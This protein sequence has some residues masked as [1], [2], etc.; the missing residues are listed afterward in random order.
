MMKKTLA[1]ATLL[2][3]LTACASTPAPAP[4]PEPVQVD[5]KPATPVDNTYKP[6]EPAKLDP[7]KDPS[8][9]LS[10]R[11]VYFDYD[12]YDVRADQAALVEAHGRY[13]ASN[14]GRSMRIEGN[15]DERGSREY[16]LALGQKR[17]E[18]VRRALST[19][20]AQDKQVEAISNGEEKPR[21]TGHDEGSYAENRRADMV[22]DGE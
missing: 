4:T 5:T 6:V 20:G 13:L 2:A 8:N 16:N 15:A 12:K 17:A 19:V 18:A 21:A 22:Y 11:G 10:K 7:L 14:P 3:L 9:V 1:S